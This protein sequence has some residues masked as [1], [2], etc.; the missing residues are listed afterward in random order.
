[1]PITQFVL[2]DGEDV[3]PWVMSIRT[4]I[5]IQAT[6]ESFVQQCDLVLSNEDGKFDGAFNV[7]GFSDGINS[8]SKVAVVLYSIEYSQDSDEPEVY[9]QLVFTGLAQKVDNGFLEC[10]LSCGTS[11]MNANGFL[12]WDIHKHKGQPTMPVMQEILAMYD[13]PAGTVQIPIGM[14]KREWLFLRDQ[15]GKAVLDYLSDW[16]G[17]ETFMNEAGQLV[18]VPPGIRGTNPDF[19]GRMKIVQA[20][21]SSLGF[22]DKVIVRGGSFLQASE[23]G[24]EHLPSN[25]VGYETTEA[26]LAMILN[27]SNGEGGAAAAAEMVAN[28]GWIR[29]PTYFVPELTTNDE[30]K[31]RAIRLLARFIT[32]WKRSMPCVVGR[33]PTLQSRILYQ[34]PRLLGAAWQMSTMQT[35]RVCRCKTEFSSTAGWVS[36]VE[37]QPFVLNQANS[38]AIYKEMETGQDATT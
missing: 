13:L 29:A 12:T 37:V 23:P 20:S 25:V 6:N 1:M 32:Y 38:D 18:H 28:F 21:E 35:G 10:K 22:C 9:V 36:W 26:D 7:V 4:D 8:L 17:H 14:E 15:S 5:A 27:N 33:S 19:T 34:Y 11:D 24:S 2:I 31:K 30:C 3:S 16:D